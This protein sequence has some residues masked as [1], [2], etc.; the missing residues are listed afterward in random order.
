MAAPSERARAAAWGALS[1]GGGL[2]G[3]ASAGFAGAAGTGEAT[4]AGGARPTVVG[5]STGARLGS[6]VAA[7][8]RSGGRC[9][10]RCAI[11]GPPARAPSG[12]ADAARPVACAESSS[13]LV[14]LFS[15][16]GSGLPCGLAGAEPLPAAPAPP[17]MR[18]GDGGG[19]LR[20]GIGGGAEPSG[21]GDDATGARPGI[22]GGAEPSGGGAE[23]PGTV[24]APGSMLFGAAVITGP[25]R[26]TGGALSSAEASGWG[27]GALRRV[28]NSAAALASSSARASRFSSLAVSAA[29]R[30]HLSASADSPRAQSALAVESCQCTS[31]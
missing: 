16:F 25:R 24:G 6:A 14:E 10:P 19:A 23:R 4:A 1:E 3:R 17:G 7:R 31:S 8:G 28:V 2:A 18:E 12:G 11:W 13:K 27:G 20:V 30:S 29:R 9:A 5:L 22:G 15:V 26:A 21:G